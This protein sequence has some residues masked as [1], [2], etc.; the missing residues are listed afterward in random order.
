MRRRN[1]FFEVVEIKSRTSK[2][3][4]IE[5][6]VP[7]FESNSVYFVGEE[8]EFIDVEDELLRFPMAEHD[9]LCFVADTK[10]LTNKGNIPIQD[11]KVGDKV[12]TRKGLR[13]VIATHNQIKPVIKNIGLEG[14][15]NHPIFTTKGIKTL[16]NIVVSDIIYIWN[17]K[18]LS[19]T[20]KSITDT[21]TRQDDNS[22]LTTGGTILGR[23]RLN[24]FIG[25]YGL[26]ILVKYLKSLLCIIK[27]ETLLII[28]SIIS[29]VFHS[30]NT[31]PLRS[32]KDWKV[33]N[34]GKSRKNILKQS[35]I[36]QVNGIGQKWVSN[37]IDNTH[38][39]KGLVKKRVYNLKI[40]DVSEYFANGILVHNCDSMAMHDDEEMAGGATLQITPIDR[41]YDP[42]TGR[43]IS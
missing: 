24:H 15:P 3:A 18:L 21:Q 32:L 9:D 16:N 6:M 40:D 22:K 23:V 8:N 36:R 17:E 7:A 43:L 29:N 38:S 12:I 26:I 10:I 37:G 4:R 5:G 11:I 39:N 28:H 14:T 25:K 33:K 27:M 31:H 20:T 34:T 1:E 35:E 2:I 41:E 30:K 19:T 13:K 42:V